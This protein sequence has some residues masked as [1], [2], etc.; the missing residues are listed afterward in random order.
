MYLS[1]Y[2]LDEKP[3][4]ISADPRFLWQGEKHREA[5]AILTYGLLE[6]NGY[7]VLTGDVG[8]GKTT[9]VNA[10]IETLDKNILV[11]NINHPTLDTLEFLSLVAKTYDASA[12]I[13]DKTDFLI[14][15]KSFLQLSYIKNKTALLIIDEAHRLSRELL[16]EIRLL[17]TME[18]AGHKLINIFFVGQN[19]LKP[20]LFSSECRALRQRITLFYDLEPLSEDETNSYIAHRLKVAGTEKKLF[21]SGAIH[22]IHDFTRGYPRL[23][24]VM[25]DRAMLT[26]YVKEQENIDADIISECASEIIFLDPMASKNEVKES[27]E[28]LISGS[29]SVD[30]SPTKIGGW[31]GNVQKEPIGDKTHGNTNILKNDTHQEPD[32]FIIKHKM[33]SDTIL[34]G[35]GHHSFN[36]YRGYRL[37]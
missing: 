2:Q 12:K 33:E 36:L 28:L 21:T 1:F 37:E 19:E 15:F 30:A 5:L 27:K 13:A 7:V 22:K 25:C 18:Q 4:K 34:A 31:E 17:S 8:T 16:E 9:L 23:I 32:S 26:G 29:P 11:A 35:C 3:F 20:T 6:E 14:F 24:N 10:L